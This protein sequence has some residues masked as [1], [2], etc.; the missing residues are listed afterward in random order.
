M[1]TLPLSFTWRAFVDGLVAEQ[2]SLAELVRV[3]YDV[4]PDALPDDPTTVE[5][6]IR[7]L[8]KKE[9]G[10]GE[11]YGRLLVRHFGLPLSIQAWA[12]ELG[13]YHSRLSELPTAVRRDQLRLWD[14]PPVSDSVQAAWIHIAVA[15]LAHQEGDGPAMLRRLQLAELAAPRAGVAAQLELALFRARV[16]SDGGED[17]QA[18]A[19]LASVP[20][21]L[22]SDDLRAHDRAC[23]H[24]RCIDQRAYRCTRH[25]REDPT[26][27]QQ[28]VALYLEI[29][30][31]G[32]AF[33]VFRHHHGLAW[34]RWKQRDDRAV[35]HAMRAS[36]AA[37]DGGFLHLR[38]QALRLH[39]RIL[40]D[41]LDAASLRSR[42]E[43]IDRD[44]Q[45]RAALD[46]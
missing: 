8:R 43:R 4:H 38:A 24:A 42:A 16:A 12:R 10:S 2:G 18:E 23:L 31:Q 27:L 46:G 39:A 45:A 34:C 35:H 22:E 32:P 30:A 25:W 17:A 26:R 13:Q 21:L 6:G 5:R 14:R 44:L 7:R 9:T 3:L 37:G 36:E 20:A 41:T 29:P 40:G 19:L 33:V 1:L 11:S 15:T 28:A